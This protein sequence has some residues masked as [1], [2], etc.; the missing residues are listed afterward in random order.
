MAFITP[1]YAKQILRM[2]ELPEATEELLT[3]HVPTRLR[4]PPYEPPEKTIPPIDQPA[5]NTLDHL[6]RLE[7]YF[8]HSRRFTESGMSVRMPALTA[9][10]KTASETLQKDPQPKELPTNIVLELTRGADTMTQALSYIPGDDKK[11][12][13]S[14]TEAQRDLRILADQLPG[15]IL[16]AAR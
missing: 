2:T 3:V 12:S 6:K 7:Y 10:L 14:A 5:L 8:A 11:L 15:P 9:A 4:I 16:G 1:A 13:Q